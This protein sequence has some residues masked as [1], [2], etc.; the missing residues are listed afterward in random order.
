MA[1]NTKYNCT[2]IL[3]YGLES[4]EYKSTFYL[5]GTNWTNGQVT[6]ASYIIEAKLEWNA[7]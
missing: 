2:N 1:E 5:P 4:A 3:Q 7:E 6:L